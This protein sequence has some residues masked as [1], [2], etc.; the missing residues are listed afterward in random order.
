METTPCETSL[1]VNKCKLTETMLTTIL[2][3]HMEMDNEIDCLH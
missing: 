2:P 3:T 1:E